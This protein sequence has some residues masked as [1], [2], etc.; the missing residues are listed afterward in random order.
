MVYI[1]Y[2]Q[3]SLEAEALG[4]EHRPRMV[5]C[6]YIHTWNITTVEINSGVHLLKR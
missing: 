6:M 2:A 1:G 5:R 4:G 3:G